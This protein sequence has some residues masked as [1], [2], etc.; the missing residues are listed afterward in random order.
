MKLGAN[1]SIYGNFPFGFEFSFC[2]SSFLYSVC[3]QVTKTDDGLEAV[4]FTA[5]GDMR[6]VS[7]SIKENYPTV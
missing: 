7:Y 1:S 2:Y 6:Q 3:Y 4:V 5:Q